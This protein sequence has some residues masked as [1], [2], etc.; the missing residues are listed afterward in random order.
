VVF[1]FGVGST[2]PDSES[3]HRSV[4]AVIALSFV[5]D[6]WPPF[7]SNR[8]TPAREHLGV[9][10]NVC[11]IGLYQ[12]W[13]MIMVQMSRFAACLAKRNG[14]NHLA[15]SHFCPGTRGTKWTPRAIFGCAVF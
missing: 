3:F 1:H 6:C 10:V 11:R 2:V 13:I 12:L 14:T 8:I 15:V 4:F 5:L 7:K 9:Y